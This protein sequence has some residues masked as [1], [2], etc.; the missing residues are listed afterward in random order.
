MHQK[1]TKMKLKSTT[2]CQPI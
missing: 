2:N 1:S